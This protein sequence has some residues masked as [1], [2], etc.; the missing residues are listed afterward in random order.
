MPLPGVLLARQ[1]FKKALVYWSLLFHLRFRA[2]GHSLRI[3]QADTITLSPR[4]L[5][6]QSSREMLSATLRWREEID[7]EAVMKEEFPKEIFGALGYNYKT[8]KEGRPVS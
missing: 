2:V 5:N 8:D 7:I 3:A 1:R 4:N 6:V